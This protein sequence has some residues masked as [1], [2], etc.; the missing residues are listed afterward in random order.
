ME[1]SKVD[2]NTIKVIEE[3]PV[4][5]KETHYDYDFLLS[6]AKQ[7]QSDIDRNQME[8]DK[9]NA[10]IAEADKL[11]VKQKEVSEA[12]PSKLASEVQP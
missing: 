12:S 8:L 7:I 11:G 3:V 9:V 10:L 2:A 5:T 6:Q 1:I 4:T